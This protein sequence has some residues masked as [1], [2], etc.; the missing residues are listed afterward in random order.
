[1]T[2]PDIYA[3][4]DAFTQFALACSSLTFTL[5]MLR[6]VA[7]LVGGKGRPRV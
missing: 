4:P 5:A 2:M 1:M 3:S 6:A 7:R